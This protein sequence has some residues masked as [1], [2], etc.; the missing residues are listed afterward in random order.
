MRI[1]GNFGQKMGILGLKMPIWGKN[2]DFF[3]IKMEILVKNGD[4]CEIKV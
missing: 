1:L 2:G 4:F 3:V